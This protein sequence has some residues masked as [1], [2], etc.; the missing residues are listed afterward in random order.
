MWQ[1]GLALLI[2]MG[3]GLWLMR[4]YLLAL[5]RRC[6][7]SQRREQ[8]AASGGCGGCSSGSSCALTQI[9]ARQ[10]GLPMVK[11]AI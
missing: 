3:A 1:N 8:P 10:A 5:G 9:K 2:V 6:T 7:G 4:D 11:R